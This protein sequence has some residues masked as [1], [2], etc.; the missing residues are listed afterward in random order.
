MSLPVWLLQCVARSG[1]YQPVP[2]E[3]PKHSLEKPKY[4][5][6]T[7]NAMNADTITVPL[8]GTGQRTTLILL[9]CETQTSQ[10]KV[11]SVNGQT[12]VG[13][14]QSYNIGTLRTVAFSL[15]TNENQLAVEMSDKNYFSA[16]VIEFDKVRN[17]QWGEASDR[18]KTGSPTTVVCPSVKASMDSLALAVGFERT[19]AAEDGLTSVST[20]WDRV[21]WVPQGSSAQTIAVAER[22]VE[23]GADSGNCIFTYPNP[24]ATNGIGRQ[25]LVST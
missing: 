3:P 19:G 20:G 2:P 17:T 7:T 24:Q 25:I 15:D 1:A 16:C 22:L 5:V 14:T 18:T 10:P 21:A 8:S 6:H 4:S 23:A 11:K 13:D 9:D 12:F